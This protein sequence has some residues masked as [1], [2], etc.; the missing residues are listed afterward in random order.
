MTGSRMTRALLASAVVMDA[1][2]WDVRRA[3]GLRAGAGVLLGRAAVH[4]GVGGR[5]A[6][7]LTAG[8]PPSLRF[9]SKEVPMGFILALSFAFLF[10]VGLGLMRR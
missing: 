3:G 5:V 6:P 8:P 9:P 2:G 4:R 7:R 10:G 1:A